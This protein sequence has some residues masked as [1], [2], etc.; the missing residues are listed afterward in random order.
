MTFH[1][2]NAVYVVQ[3][4]PETQGAAA[5]ALAH[6]Y[7]QPIYA[8][9]LFSAPD[10]LRRTMINWERV[11]DLATDAVPRV[12]HGGLVAV[13][14]VVE[15]FTAARSARE[16]EQTGELQTVLALMAWA[17]AVRVRVAGA[18]VLHRMDAMP[19][20]LK[21]MPHVPT[22]HLLIR[23]QSILSHKSCTSGSLF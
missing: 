2:A 6:C 5:V 23:L 12:V 7:C 10:S 1:V 21:V 16:S 14:H 9:P 22:T 17:G 3:A 18:H 15:A 20:S 4:T 13:N 8:V 19:A 11:A